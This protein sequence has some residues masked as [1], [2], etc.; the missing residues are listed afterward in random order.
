MIG[1]PVPADPGAGPKDWRLREASV[2]LR[3]LC[4]GLA[5]NVVVATASNAAEP[6][7]ARAPG[8]LSALKG[9]WRGAGEAVGKRV[10][11]ALIAR[12][13]PQDAMFAFDV[14]SSAEANPKDRYSAHLLFGGADQSADA[15]GDDITG[16]WADSFGGAYTATGRGKTRQDGFDVT[17]PYP[18]DTFVNRWRLSGDRLTWTIV[19]RDRKGQEKAFAHYAMTKVPCAVGGKR[20]SHQKP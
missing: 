5:V 9:C 1:A 10:V 16:F 2:T 4:L 3:R 13:I 6:G 11:V 19:A 20:I 18:D 15:D 8:A 17:Y 7:A 12:P 14:E